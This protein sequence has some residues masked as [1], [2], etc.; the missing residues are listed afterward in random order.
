LVDTLR[1]PVRNRSIERGLK[2]LRDDLGSEMLA[3]E[4][5]D[6]VRAG[7]PYTGLRGREGLVELSAPRVQEDANLRRPLE[8]ELLA[9]RDASGRR[10]PVVVRLI[11]ERDVR[12]L[13][14]DCCHVRSGT[15]VLRG[16]T[17]VS[18]EIEG[19][20]RL[21]TVALPAAT[22]PAAV[23]AAAPAAASVPTAGATEEDWI[24]RE[25]ARFGELEMPEHLLQ[26]TTRIDPNLMLASVPGMSSDPAVLARLHAIVKRDIPYLQGRIQAEMHGR[27]AYGLSCFLMVAMGA[28]LGILFRGGQLLSAFVLSVVPAAVVILLILSGKQMLGNPGVPRV[29]GLAAVWGG[30]VVLLAGNVGLYARLARKS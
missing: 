5:T 21:R 22:G 8:A 17:V 15:S 26:A 25:K 4:V 2:T 13:E 20:V 14:A 29:H 19:D 27:L 11:G 18:L 3:A 30:I 16:G 12:I 10:D 7:R 1:N 24:Q 23:P 9:R 28:A 6:A